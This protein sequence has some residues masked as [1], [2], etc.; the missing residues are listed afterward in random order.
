MRII[1]CVR[2]IQCKHTYILHAIEIIIVQFTVK[3]IIDIDSFEDN[4]CNRS[5]IYTLCIIVM[6]QFKDTTANSKSTIGMYNIWSTSIA[7]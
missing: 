1:F 3:V 2:Q 4:C 5:I 7:Y 6:H